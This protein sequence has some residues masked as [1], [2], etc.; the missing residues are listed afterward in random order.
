MGQPK[1]TVI[2]DVSA[3]SADNVLYTA[4]PRGDKPG[5]PA[6]AF[7]AGASAA[8][9]AALASASAGGTAFPYA[10]GHFEPS[11]GT[12]VP[13]APHSAMSID[14]RYRRAYPG[15]RY[16]V[17]IAIARGSRPFRFRLLDGPVGLTVVETLPL[18][19]EANGPGDYSR[20]IWPNP[21]LGNHDVS[22]EVEGQDGT[23]VIIDFQINCTTAGW[24]FVDCI[25]G[26][27]SSAN[28]GTGTGTI[29]NPF[30]GMRDW[31]AGSI[32]GTG[33]ATKNDSTYADYF[34]VYRDSGASAYRTDD[35]FIEDASSTPRLAMTGN[36]KPMV[37]M[38]YPGETAKISLQGGMWIW[39][40]NSQGNLHLGGLTFKDLSATSRAAAGFLLNIGY[41]GMNDCGFDRCKFERPTN[42]GQP[43][44]N[45]SMV[46][47]GH[48]V[49]GE[50][51]YMMFCEFE[52]SN[53]HDFWLIYSLRH[54][55]VEWN[56]HPGP[57]EAGSS[58][59][60]HAY[61]FKDSW[62]NVTC[63]H[64]KALHADNDAH[65]FRFDGWQSE[66]TPG[67]MEV[68][69]CNMYSQ[70]DAIQFGPE[71]TNLGTDLHILR[72]TIHG[73]NPAVLVSNAQ[74]TVKSTRNVIRYTG[75]PLS[76]ST[77]TVTATQNLQ[78]ASGLINSDGLLTGTDR[79]NYL[80][81]RGHEAA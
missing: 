57:N 35:A 65:L 3:R 37:H 68:V 24:I 62:Q 52:G 6:A 80:G 11:T 39:Y 44:M 58:G 23:S 61:Y 4:Y 13:V 26:H 2:F 64:I 56:E 69:Y 40:G 14:H 75:S 77:M 29:S 21:V 8:V 28:G 42:Q 17:A 27:R 45:G 18:N 36:R 22:L 55:V 30:L 31:Y 70:V 10:S 79:T 41:S 71:S 67:G 81:I 15:M 9:S 76:N 20:L 46:F 43:S 32:G 73:G 72:N 50:R 1:P 74:G 19:V 60:G 78:A 38:A 47:A 59:T 34:V 53:G 16:D 49:M 63:A 5:A 25:N 7:G 54:V 48:D 66:A 12:M 51:H 33:G